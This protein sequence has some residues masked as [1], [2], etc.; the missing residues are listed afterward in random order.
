MTEPKSWRLM[1]LKLTYLPRP[2]HVESGNPYIDNGDIVWGVEAPTGSIRHEFSDVK[3]LGEFLRLAHS[4]DDQLLKFAR[5][6]GPLGLCV[7]GAPFGHRKKSSN[8]RCYEPGRRGGPDKSNPVVRLTELH[9][10][11]IEG[12]RRYSNRANGVLTVADKLRQ[13]KRA[14]ERDWQW[15]WDVGSRSGQIDAKK[16]SR[17]QRLYYGGRK[18][19]P[20]V[21][22]WAM[23]VSRPRFKAVGKSLLYLLNQCVDNP[24]AAVVAMGRRDTLAAQ[25]EKLAQVVNHW[26]DE[27][28]V[29]PCINWSKSDLGVRLGL[30]DPIGRGNRLLIVIVVQLICAVL[31]KDRLAVC[32]ACAEWYTPHRRPRE[33]EGSF[34]ES[35]G[36]R[37]ANRLAKRRSRAKRNSA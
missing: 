5:K 6:Y 8:T 25:K 31:G 36:K 28:E 2:L 15:L 16:A 7:H 3:L 27:C 13:D 33:G 34:C 4:T 35:C 19:A 32:T 20:A 21:T 22:E 23:P 10:E 26:L 1:D 11:S 29:G 12:W 30:S 24:L 17:V 37:A 9:R 18:V 14:S